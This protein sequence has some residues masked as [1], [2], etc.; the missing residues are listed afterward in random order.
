MTPLSKLKVVIVGQDPY[1]GPN[2]GHGLC[3]SVRKGI[4]IPPSL[5]NIYK[6][7]LN[8]GR[9]SFGSKMNNQ[10]NNDQGRPRKPPTH[11]FL[12]HWATQGVLLLNTVLTVR[13]GQANSHAKKGWEQFTDYIIQILDHEYTKPDKKGLVF[14]LWGKPASKKAAR[15]LGKKQ[16]AVICTSHPSPLGASKT[17]S[18][19]LGSKCFSKANDALIE[20]GH[21]PI[22][23]NVD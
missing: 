17:N 20:R 12:E 7:L 19:F 22:D 10:T 9:V 21:E 14:L 18:P 8:D 4:M 3:F 1:H 2:Q 15:I 11:G 5:R 13:R 23:W 6:E 16:H